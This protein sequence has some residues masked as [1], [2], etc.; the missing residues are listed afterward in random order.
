M[1]QTLQKFVEVPQL[2]FLHGFGRPCDHAETLSRDS[3]DATDSIHRRSPWTFQ[4]PQRQVRTVAA[5]HGRPGGGD[6]GSL[7]QFCS[8]FRPPSIWTLRP[9]VAETPGV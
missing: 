3:E 1:V 8:I 4:S 6:E 5:V 2:Q 7:L 9:R